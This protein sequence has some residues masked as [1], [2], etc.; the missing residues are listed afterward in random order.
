MFADKIKELKEKVKFLE[1]EVFSDRQQKKRLEDSIMESK[2][3]VSETEKNI[4]IYEKASLFLQSFSKLRREEGQA[5]FS[6]MGT[7]ALQNIYGPGYRLEIQYD[8]KR[9]KPIAD[10]FIVSPYADTKDKEIYYAS[11]YAAGGE[12]DVIS[13]AMK[14]ALL[15]TYQPLQEGPVLLDET[16]KHLSVDHIDDV[17]EMLSQISEHLERQ[18]IF[19]TSHRHPSFRKCADKAFF[20]ERESDSESIVVEDE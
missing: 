16:F 2:R 6:D 5:I 18:F 8:V 19:C 4:S 14:L 7:V 13:F 10:V 3:V 15:Q 20:V 12:N 17:A 11:G 9:S 1:V